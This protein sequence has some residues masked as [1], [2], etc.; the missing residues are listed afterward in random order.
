MSE[1]LS[2]DQRIQI[3]ALAA[4]SPRNKDAIDV[5]A[6]MVAAIN[7]EEESSGK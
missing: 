3:M 2:L 6:E 4:N 7:P 5:Y 1:Y